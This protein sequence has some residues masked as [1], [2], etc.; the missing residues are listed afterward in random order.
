[1]KAYR[2]ILSLTFVVASLI[3]LSAAAQST[4]TSSMAAPLPAVERLPDANVKERGATPQGGD[5]AARKKAGDVE[6]ILVTTER[7]TQNLQDIAAVTKAVTGDDLRLQGIN[8][9]TDLSN[10]LPQLN[11]G[12]REGNVEVFIRGIGDDNN[13]ELSEPRSAILLDGVYISRPRGLGS[14]FFDIE[15]VELNIGPQGTLRGRNATGGSLNIVS[16][17]PK[18]N[19]FEGYLDAGLGNFSQRE[20]QGA[21]N[22][23][24]TDDLSVRLAGYYLAHDSKIENVGP[25]DGIDESR[26]TE[27]IAFRGS[28]RWEPTSRLSLTVTTDFLDSRGTGYGGLDFFPYYQS[29]FADT[30]T[31]LNIN[32]E[33]ED[34]DDPYQSVTQGAQPQQDQQIWGVRGEARYDF[35]YLSVEY[36]GAYR[37]TDFF[38]NRT[39]S[40][41][42]FPEFEEFFGVDL[43][44]PNPDATTSD[45]LNTFNRVQFDQVFNSMVHELRVYANEDQRLRWTAGAFFFQETGETYFNTTADR[46]NVFAGV[47][48][49]MPDVKRESFAFYAD[50]TF[51]ILK[52]LRVTGG[53]R[54]T[55]ESLERRGFGATYLFLFPTETTA[56][57]PDTFNFS[58]C[59][60]QRFG[61][62]GMRFAGRDRTLYTGDIDLDN[63]QDVAR[64]FQNGIARY[65]LSDDIDDQ[66]DL[67]LR[68]GPDQ[69]GF[70]LADRMIS[71]IT[72]NDG[73][74]RDQ[75]IN[76]RARVEADVASNSLVYGG[77]TTGTNSGG[78]NDSVQ[79]PAG[80]ISPEFDKEDVLVAEVGSKNKFNIFGYQAIVN[81]AG[82][83]YTYEDQQF[84]VLAPAGDATMSGNSALVSLRQ[85]VGD[86]RILGFDLD[87]TQNLPFYLRLR[88]NVQYLNTEFTDPSGDLVDTRFNFP[89]GA[90]DTLSFDPTGNKLPKASDW[91]GMVSLAQFIPT[92]IGWFEWVA[93]VGFRSEYFLTIFNGDGTLPEINQANF[94]DLTEEEVT[95]LSNTVRGS[96]GSSSDLVNGYIRLDLGAAYNPT[97][98]IRIE[99]YG[100]NVTNR[101]YTQTALVSPGLNLRFLNDP[102]TFG[103][104]VRVK[105]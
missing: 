46:G 93:S 18:L 5:A 59:A 30:D 9:F 10:A 81:V 27:D 91:S 67:L 54:Y 74:R 83:W 97:D 64:L 66:L 40:D 104:R 26:K 17:K 38:F 61:S 56:D 20:L 78:F 23:P 8:S 28:I 87:Y 75:F 45:F 60:S 99:L 86:S 49:A 11:V 55:N 31:R 29:Q 4:E 103:G 32:N 24:V 88:A 3:P 85:N 14:F 6:E 94:P 48:F 58:C 80:I 72:P 50:A 39:S 16:A 12:N 62:Q 105:F 76:W 43:G 15:R 101:A 77:L 79:T 36:L 89:N 52:W 70:G 71:N 68:E 41:A 90:N 42:Y 98:K 13:T 69:T 84:T 25:L 35:G 57:A 63:P 100:K 95:N 65:G 22:I 19:V 96:A 37:S 102:R 47:E 53:I 34:L 33:I 44:N 2:T 73:E 82:F 1:M 21:I 7:R 92:P 51:D